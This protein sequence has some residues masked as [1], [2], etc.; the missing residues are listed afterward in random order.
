M[1]FAFSI[2]KTMQRKYT[3]LRRQGTGRNQLDG[4]TSYSLRHENSMIADGLYLTH[5]RLSDRIE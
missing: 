4:E 3:P 5:Q 1:L 2:A